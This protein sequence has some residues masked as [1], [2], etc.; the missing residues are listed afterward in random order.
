MCPPC[1]VHRELCVLDLPV[2]TLLMQ[3]GLLQRL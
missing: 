2:N 1:H 3:A